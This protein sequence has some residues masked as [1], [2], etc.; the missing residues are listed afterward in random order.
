MSIARFII[1]IITLILFMSTLVI[2]IYSCVEGNWSIA[3]V[4]SMISA[5][6]AYFVYNDY[7]RLFVYKENK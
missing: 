3:V 4:T 2:M 7:L 1:S 6:F 5:G